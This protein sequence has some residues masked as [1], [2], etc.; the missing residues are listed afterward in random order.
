[1]NSKAS[2]EGSSK[3]VAVKRL[4]HS[5]GHNIELTLTKRVSRGLDGMLLLDP[6]HLCSTFH[7]C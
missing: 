5:I 1:M 3:L 4:E 2:S 7:V 6:S